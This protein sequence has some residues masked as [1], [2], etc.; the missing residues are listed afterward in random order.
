MADYHALQVVIHRLGCANTDKQPCGGRTCRVLQ[1][2][3]AKL[4]SVL[5]KVKALD[6]STLSR[7]CW[8]LA[9][10]AEVAED[11]RELLWIQETVNNT[12]RVSGCSTVFTFLEPA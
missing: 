2:L 11:P 10:A 1:E 3:V 6:P 12:R 9:V 5:R 7:V 8:P 4:T